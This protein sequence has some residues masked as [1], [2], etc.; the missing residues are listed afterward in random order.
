MRPAWLALLAVP[1]L[2]DTVFRSV[3]AS[4]SR[5]RPAADTGEARWLVLVP[6]RDEGPA[7]EPTL[8][9][10]LAA[11][12]RHDVRPLL[13]LDGDD[14]VAATVA[15]RLGV[16]V[17][18]KRP[19][20]PSKAATLAWYAREFGSE[21]ERCDTVLVLDVGSL[22]DVGFFAGSW[23]RGADAAQAFLRGTGE[24]PGRAIALSERRAQEREDLG[25]EALG[26]AVRLRG[27]GT[28]LT[29]AVFRSLMP[30]LRTTVEDLEISLLLAASGARVVMMP[31]R[32]AVRDEKP[33]RIGLAAGQRARWLAGRI[34]LLLRRPRALARLVSKRPI[35]GVAFAAELLGRP[36]S[37]TA[38]ARLVIA[39]VLAGAAV[40][41]R[42]DM[43][44]VV[45]AALLVASVAADAAL[46]G[47]QDAAASA[48]TLLASWLAALALLPR[49]FLG[50]IKG[51][52]P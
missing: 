52:R 19:A 18:V 10:V 22:V 1:P 27:T 32:A 13:L 42:G 46:V 11:G 50:W 33:E 12:V 28:A 37:L 6:A 21:L 5:R 45:L 9:S 2:L 43:V 7:V 34:Q 16:E 44:E 25:R 17:K 8:I 30:Q 3:L 47:A 31:P 40:S 15:A 26:W 29:P 41:G 36:L 23:P 49:A 35:E 4:S 20:G 14:I 39:S 38:L 51:R 24:G 48:G